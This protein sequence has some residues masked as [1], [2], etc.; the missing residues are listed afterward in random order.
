MGDPIEKTVAGLGEDD[1]EDPITEAAKSHGDFD[2]TVAIESAQEDVEAGSNEDMIERMF[3]PPEV[4]VESDE[5]Q[6]RDEAYMR[7]VTFV[8]GRDE[9]DPDPNNEFQKAEDAKER[10]Q[11]IEMVNE[12]LKRSGSIRRYVANENDAP[13]AAFIYEDE[14]GKFYF[15]DLDHQLSPSDVA[16]YADVQAW[17]VLTPEQQVVKTIEVLNEMS[18][19]PLVHAKTAQQAI[20]W[21]KRNLT[22]PE[23]EVSDDVFD[24]DFVE[25]TAEVVATAEVADE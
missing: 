13:D 12:E 19:E 7:S 11:E 3:T 4:E 23:D 25:R 10:L 24:P 22:L 5:P 8:A 16:K 1:G 14:F 2:P 9:V 18:G 15:E 17:P 20:S 6:S 21:F